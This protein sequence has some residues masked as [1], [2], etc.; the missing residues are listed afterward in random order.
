[1]KTPEDKFNAAL[2]LQH[3]PLTF[4]D[5]QL[6][7]TNPDNHLLAHNLFKSA[8]EAGYKETVCISSQAIKKYLDNGILSFRLRFR[9]AEARRIVGEP[10]SC[11][12]F[13]WSSRSAAIL[14]L[15]RRKRDLLR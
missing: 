3:T 10:K 9:E 12:D 2:V 4:C 5:K 15:L 7:S 8:F 14:F 1:V 6:V 13:V 11:P